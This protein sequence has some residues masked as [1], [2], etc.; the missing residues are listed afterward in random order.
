MRLIFAAFALAFCFHAVAADSIPSLSAYSTV[1]GETKN[2]VAVD[3]AKDLPRYSAVE[4]KDAVA[5]WKMKRGFK[6]ELA[7]SEP[8]VRSPVAVSFDENGRMFVAEMIDYP[9]MRDAKPHLGR[10]SML[11]DKDG[12]GVYETSTVFAE[13]LPW[14]TGVIC[15]NGGIYVIATPDVYFLKDTKGTGK[16]DARE[17]V[18]TGFGTGLKLLNV[19]G[20]ANCPQW[21]LDNRIHVQAGGGNR[22]KVKCLKRPDLPEV[23]IA[24]HDFWFDPRTY[25]FGLEAGG[26]QYGMSF[27]DQGRRFACGN[28]DHLQLFVY[29]DRLPVRNPAFS[30]PDPRRSIAADGGAAEVYRVS[31]DEPWRIVRTRWRIAGVVR[32]VVEGGGRVSGYFTGATGATVYRG[33]AYGDDFANNVFVGDAGGQLVHRKKLYLDGVSLIGRRPA[34]EQNFEFGA[35]TDTWVRP[36]NFANAPDGCLHVIDM[37]REVIE[38]PWSIPDEIKKHLDLNSGNDRGRIYRIVP[39]G[40]TAP[41]LRREV[42]L[43]NASAGELVALLM[44]PNG[45]H[46]DCAA[47][48]LYERQD[49]AAAP[50]LDEIMKSPGNSMAKIHALA[51]LD[52]LN[53]LNARSVGAALTDKDSSVRERGVV[54]AIMFEQRRAAREGG[55]DYAPA[56]WDAIAPL[57]DDPSPRVRFHAALAAGYAGVNVRAPFLAKLA[58][59]DSNDFW[60]SAA[61]LNGA[62]HQ[63][64]ASLQPRLGKLEPA[65]VEGLIG[66]IAA[67]PRTPA[68]NAALFD[69]LTAGSPNA[70]WIRAFGEALKKAGNAIPEVDTDKKLAAIFEKAASAAKDSSAA[71]PKRIDSI[72][73]LT[74]APPAQAESALLV[75]IEDG[76]PEIVQAA[77]LAAL[78]RIPGASITEAI[79]AKWA[80]LQNRARASAAAVLLARPERSLALL[81]A[82]AA[83]K[84]AAADL[85]TSDAQALFQHKDKEVAALASSV[86]ASLKPPARASVIARFQPAIGAKGN[87]ERGQTLYLQRCAV[88]HRASNLGAQ[89]GPDLVT[90]KTKGRDGVMTAILDPNKEVAAQYIAYTVETKDGQTLAGIIV[91]DDASSLTL[92]MA[93]GTETSILRSNVKGSSS[94]GLSLMPEGLEAGLQMQDM[95][96]LLTF[97]E[98]LQ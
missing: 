53:A 48:L 16:A 2:P 84:I 26:G 44:H 86:L 19:Q 59:S 39:D 85:T 29:D 82:I 52:G 6:I 92:R 42:S 66:V 28:S 57:A 58:V 7:A 43:G 4:P 5:T 94:S 75:C 63:L 18:F 67:Q 79:I 93:G 95:A 97:I 30:M 21:G 20:L 17:V 56:F 50:M 45:W 46:R 62:E 12:D 65:F 61:V 81:N 37:Y 47:R 1:Y 25:D 15:A 74:V 55:P 38:H 89:V 3:P 77:A 76:Q 22:G 23:E 33:G 35:S 14:P 73:I 24:G 96:D 71:E 32:G 80:G 88:C 87:A 69:T 98:D 27:D 64:F 36:V 34:D 78:G 40:P 91:K 90:V 60:I 9:E 83:K 54:T 68:T 41:Q 10:I 49:H 31:P 8:Q 72:H 51:V 70:G 11:E 13:D